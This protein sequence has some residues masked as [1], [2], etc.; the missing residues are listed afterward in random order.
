LRLAARAI[1]EA[2]F[3]STLLEAMDPVAITLLSGALAGSLYFQMRRLGARRMAWRRAAEFCGL[4]DIQE[5][6]TLGV[7]TGLRGRRGRLQVSV[8]S[9]TSG[10]MASVTFIQ[11][12]GIADV[13]MRAEG[14]DTAM[15]KTLRR[16]SEV[17]VG[18]PVFDDA[19]YLEGAPAVLQAV[20]DATTRL[21]VRRLLEGTLYDA[22][23]GTMFMAKARLHGRLE[24]HVG[25]GVSG[26]AQSG[27]PL[28]LHSTLELA[29]RLVEPD[30]V[31]A[32]LAQNAREDPLPE[33]RRRNLVMLQRE[34]PN[35]AAAAR[36]L[37]AACTDRDEEVRLHAAIQ[38]GAAGRSVLRAL[39]GSDA[40]D[41]CSA[42]AV[43][44]LGLE[45]APAEALELMSRALPRRRVA[46]AIACIES[47]AGRGGAVTVAALERVLTGDVRP[48][49][50]AAARALGLSGLEDGAEMVL[51][52]R[53]I[54]HSD[55]GV[56]AAAAEAL[57][58]A[59]R[60]AA[61]QPLMELAQRSPI[62]LRRTV[63]QAIAEI[64]SRLRGAAPGQ[65]TV[66][67]TEGG[68]VSLAT[69]GGEVSLDGGPDARPERA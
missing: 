66:A 14:I 31:P 27:L 5:A 65:L 50:E 44:G 20:L 7:V 8:D 54:R 41:S 53:G 68:T 23:R 37:E 59:G 32:R 33:V 30:D 55:E 46:T 61:V 62:A 1:D 12:R 64:Q 69:E 18:D 29:R 45:L 58:R 67:A 48:A 51:L 21:T 56:R 36:A 25:E 26:F 28:A 47:L 6:R 63:Q 40:S 3:F 22:S 4:Q 16:L 35:H 49:A 13:A 42:R 17:E 38:R 60:V 10:R 19:V 11:V 15:Q 9:G 39:A 43:R 52:A 57:G 2:G 34:F 24:L